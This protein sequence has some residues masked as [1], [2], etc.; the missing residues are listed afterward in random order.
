M[1]KKVAARA[2]Y[3]MT[4]I[5]TV[6]GRAQVSEKMRFENILVKITQISVLQILIFVNIK[7]SHLSIQR[8]ASRPPLS[9]FLQRLPKILQPSCPAVLPVWSLPFLDL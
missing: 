8:I 6:I 5:T 4:A 9:N 2:A 7:K 3:A 1:L